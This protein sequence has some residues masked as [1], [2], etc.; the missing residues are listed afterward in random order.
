MAWKHY[1]FSPRMYQHLTL[2][3]CV[4]YYKTQ[5]KKGYQLTRGC[6]TGAVSVDHCLGSMP[7]S[8]ERFIYYSSLNPAIRW[9]FLRQGRSKN[10]KDPL[11]ILQKNPEH[12]L[13]ALRLT[14]RPTSNHQCSSFTPVLSHS[15]CLRGVVLTPLNFL[16]LAT[17]P[18][19]L[20][21]CTPIRFVLSDLQG[22]STTASPTLS[23][24]SVCCY[25]S[26]LCPKSGTIYIWLI[27]LLWSPTPNRM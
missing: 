27:D 14:P 7:G 23:F 25:Y 12:G 5:G 1:F 8:V 21:L 11:L 15:C 4:K 18:S 20:N 6:V 2:K 17:V 24:P 22:H 13:L 19:P 9:I 3:L 16:P 10:T 26:A